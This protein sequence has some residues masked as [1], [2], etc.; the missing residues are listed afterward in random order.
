MKESLN[1]I[2]I[3]ALAL[4]S[5]LAILTKDR[6]LMSLPLLRTVKMNSSPWTL[7]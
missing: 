7:L 2:W 3:A 5:G 1:D 4:E 6:H